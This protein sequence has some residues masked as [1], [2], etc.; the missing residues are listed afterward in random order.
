M[1]PSPELE[2]KIVRTKEAI[3]KE[4]N[5]TGIEDIDIMDL[6]TYTLIASRPRQTR[7]HEFVGESRDAAPITGT[8]KAIVLL[9][10]FSD[11]AA[12]TGQAHYNS[13]LFSQ[14]S[15]ATGSMRD[16]Y[17]EASYGQLDVTG[18]V[19][20]SGGPTAG[21]FRAP[22]PKSYYT[23]GNFGFNAYPKNAQKLAEDAIDL[24]NPFV[25]FSQYDNDG[26]GF[27]EALV[28]ICAGSGGEQTGNTSDI[29]SH[30]WSITPK[31]VD[32]VKIDRYFMAPEDGRVGVMAHELGH[33]LLGL[34][35]LYD[36][37]YSSR[38][39]GN[40]DLMAGG[41]WN[42]GGNTPAHPTA[43]CKVKCGWVNPSVIF[44]QELD[45]TVRPYKDNKDIFKLPIGDVNSKEYYLIS[46][47]RKLGFDAGIPGEGLLI[48]HIDENKTNNTDENHYLVDVEQADGLRHLNINANNGDANDPFPTASNSQFTI[49]SS[50]SSKT[51]SGADSKVSVT[52]IARSGS[53]VTAKVNVGGVTATTMVTKKVL[54]TYATPHSMN[55]WAYIDSV[56]W[57]K[58]QDISPNGVTAFFIALV[59]AR[60]KNQQVTVQVDGTN[61]SIVYY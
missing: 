27:V 35:D 7:A 9:V 20:G 5:L 28:I 11:R 36:T 37:D 31:T 14:G 42:G 21:W 55:A 48:E 16:F 53:N 29:W 10:D 30:K 41:S 57:R 24:A 8:R 54:M 23:D 15:Y 58:V 43:W 33:L 61:M 1:P 25:S 6:R 2:E 38:G 47:R 32:G 50:P 13:L 4:A 3:I 52:N 49:S 26:D 18:A 51:Y 59:Q 45:I 12:A 17:K 44:N 60:V 34:P 22:S 39:T 19:S 56:G 46:N 40:W